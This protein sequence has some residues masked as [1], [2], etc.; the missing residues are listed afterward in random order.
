MIVDTATATKQ[1][2][3]SL[4][5][6]EGAYVA[7]CQA[8]LS[9]TATTMRARLARRVGA[10]LN[11]PIE[12]IKER[13]LLTKR[14]SFR[15]LTMSITVSRQA[16]PLR[17]YLGARLGTLVGR[18]PRGGISVTVRK[19]KAE[20][21]PHAFVAKMPSGRVLLVERARGAKMTATVGRYRG[22][23]REVL[24]DRMAPTVVGVLA[25][26]Y[27]KSGQ[28]LV[29]EVMGD[30]NEVFLKN[31]YSQV[32]RFMDD[33]KGA[34]RIAAAAAKATRGMSEPGE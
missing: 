22:R 14:P 12:K 28:K 30:A 26:G 32:D 6:I 27:G 16:L 20:R 10:V 9:R 17:M 19:G 24:Q 15:D 1:V 18:Q 34:R 25:Q 11:L 23:M 2:Q 4:A 3:Q 31:L 8:A 21:Y 33:V 7:A 5:K 13:A 29:D